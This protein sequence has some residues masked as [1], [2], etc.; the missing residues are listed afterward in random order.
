MNRII[1]LLGKLKYYFLFFMFYSM[2]TIIKKCIEICMWF[3]IDNV[4]YGAKINNYR[5]DNALISSLAKLHATLN[6]IK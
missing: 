5:I 4:P 6:R 3:E 1:F 2:L